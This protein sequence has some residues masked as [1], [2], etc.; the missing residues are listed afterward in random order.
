M[1]STKVKCLSTDG[2]SSIRI[3]GPIGESYWDD[4][5]TTARAFVAALEPLK[6]KPVT[7]YVNSEGGS[8]A[9]GLEIYNAIK[10]HG[11]VTAYIT[12][13]ALSIASLFPLAAN[14]VHSPKG[15]VWMLHKPWSYQ[16]GN[17]DDMRKAAEM[18]DKNEDAL[19]G[20]YAEET[21]QPEEKI[22]ADL[23]A[24][25]WMT[26][27]E[28][29]A[30]G[31]ADETNDEPVVLAKLDQSRYRHLPAAFGGVTPQPKQKQKGSEMEPTNNKPVAAEPTPQP[32]KVQDGDNKDAAVLMA[33]IADL[34][35]RLDQERKLRIEKAVDSAVAEGQI[36]VESSAT[37]VAKIMADESNMD[38]LRG[39]P[40]P[41]RNEQPNVGPGVQVGASCGRD[42][43][44]AKATPR[45]RVQLMVDN[46]NEF[47]QQG[48]RFAPQAANTGTDSSTLLG[49]ML[50]Q[51]TVTVLQTVL[52][53]LLSFSYEAASDPMVPLQPTIIR[54][55]TAGG[56]AQSNTTDFEDTTNF[57]GTV[58]SKTVTPARKTSGGYLT[59]TEY[60]SGNK[61]AQWAEIK[62]QEIGEA[63][64]GVVTAL[65]L[66]GTFT[67][68]IQTIAS[69]AFTRS[70]L[71][72]LWGSL[73]KARTKNAILSSTYVA[74]LL[75]TYRE[76]F[77]ILEGAHAGWNRIDTNDYWT[78]ATTNTVGFACH[79]QAIG[80]VM[81]APVTPPTA[82]G[83]GLSQSNITIPGLG[84][85][86]Q[87]SSW[88]NT[89]TRSDWFTL[90]TVIGAAV[91][92][93]TAGRII[94]SA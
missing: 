38:L 49:T 6:N 54:V 8:V 26:G 87:M 9:D 53:P 37:W 25:T 59:V 70:D 76:E 41:M 30:Y 45:E 27:D 55:T 62:A 51:Q 21:G 7:L 50:D 81:G 48:R 40:K 10:A 39:L 19:V 17:A 5:G 4:S 73:N 83:A 34:N 61:M 84:S 74:K 75:P 57:V 90:D 28:A 72:T 65:I 88:F 94:K 13:Y 12:G 11:N 24:E 69:V 44:M 18:L 14:K 80:V 77:N 78:G 89:A 16:G 46:W 60:N 15:S 2:E 3:S 36:A 31:L 35:Q 71:N 64:L 82:A 91:V 58:T 23:T 32:A 22:R 29:V 85:V 52:G 93:A 79:P 47:R 86:V 67:T 63:A 33:K 1:T 43:V 92:D 42:H 66:T 56:T 20:I 68:D